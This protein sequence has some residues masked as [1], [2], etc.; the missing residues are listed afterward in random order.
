MVYE[1]TGNEKSNMTAFKSEVLI[2][3]LVGKIGTKDQRLYICMFTRTS[4][5]MRI[6]GVNC[7]LIP[8]SVIQN[9]RP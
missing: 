1:Q 8:E 6:T 9:W 5:P 7:D 2:S 4:Y 3:K